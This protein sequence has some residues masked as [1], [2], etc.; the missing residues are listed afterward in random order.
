VGRAVAGGEKV[1]S[2]MRNSTEYV[3]S[4]KVPLKEKELQR[5]K[6]TLS[7]IPDDV[8][9]ILDIGCGDGRITN[10]LANSYRV[11]GA[12]LASDR[13]N[14]L[15]SAKVCM[16]II[17]PAFKGA[18]FDLVMLTEIL[19]HLPDRV[20]IDALRE[21]QRVSKK[22]ILITIPYRENLSSN[23]VKCAECGTVFHAWQHLR[24]FRNIESLKKYFPIYAPI[25]HSFFGTGR[26]YKSDLIIF[27][28]QH[29]GKQWHKPGEDIVCPACKSRDFICKGSNPVILVCKVMEKFLAKIIP[30]FNKRWVGVLYAKKI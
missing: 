5:I 27:V 30:K 14:K 9:T 21:I 19:E 6:A 2:N 13:L 29:L 26:E 20:F 8:K 18:S 7:L 25:K 10:R 24:S 15:A 16:N 17:A 23:F 3:T 4:C 11:V 1:N 28:K 12:D 22:Y